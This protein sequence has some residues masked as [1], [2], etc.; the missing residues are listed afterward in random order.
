MPLATPTLTNIS[1]KAQIYFS[2]SP[3]HF[4]FQNALADSNIQKV[5]VEVYVWRGLQTA[6]LPPS[7][8]FV[9][10]N[11]NK[12]SPSDDYIALSF[13]NEIK[14]FI[15]TSNL[16]KH[17]PQ[18]AYNTLGL[19]ASA[20]EGVF[21]HIVYKVD[22][23]SVQQLG[24][25]FATMGY[26]YNYE[27]LNGAFTT[28]DDVETFRRYANGIRYDRFGISLAT[29]KAT[30]HSG[31][32]S[33]ITQ[34]EVVPTNREVQTGVACL[35][36]Y[37]NRLGLW[38]SFTPFGKVVETEEIKRDSYGVSYR[39]PLN[40][41]SQLQHLQ[42]NDL[43]KG[44]RK[45]SINTSLI[46][47]QNNYQIKEINQSSKIYLVIF[48]DKLTYT[49]VDDGIT[50]DTTDY[51]VDDTTIT[52]DSDI[53]TLLDVGFYREFIQ[54]PVKKSNNTYVKKTRL[55]D[56]SSISYT[57]EFEEVNNLINDI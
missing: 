35:V 39:N 12:V 32:G 26:R 5:T 14:S 55:N 31:A 20:G 38:D 24:T 28:Y 6:D 9:F 54:I 1:T 48:E 47:E 4:N 45:W 8:T 40:V 34:T 11:V 46:D 23:E 18:W 17:N 19:S 53:V 15:Q 13:H 25:Y 10:S 43:A 50:V 44:T 49:A 29:D 16:N 7:P 22:S 42:G 36:V 27:K 3:I 41:N 52:V 57:L 33:I 56:K 2:E 37:L 51:T 30:A 21:F